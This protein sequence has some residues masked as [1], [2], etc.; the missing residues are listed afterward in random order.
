MYWWG[1]R[2][3]GLER[4]RGKRDPPVHSEQRNLEGRGGTCVIVEK[5]SG[6]GNEGKYIPKEEE[7]ESLQGVKKTAKEKRIK[8]TDKL[9]KS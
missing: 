8:D 6:M 2:A 1:S 9:P 3:G 5:K 7:G 4:K